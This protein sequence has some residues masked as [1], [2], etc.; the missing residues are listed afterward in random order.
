VVL[1][2]VN[3]SGDSSQDTFVDGITDSLT[4]DLSKI[5][6]SYAPFSVIARNTAFA[7]K[8]KNVDVRQIG[9]DLGVR[10]ALEGS[11]QRDQ[12]RVRVNVQLVDAESG[13]HVWTERFDKP[14]AD[15]FALQDEIVMQVGGQLKQE[16][17]KADIRRSQGSS[18]PNS[19][20]LYRQATDLV[21][22]S[23]T[24]DDMTKARDLCRRAV[25][26]DPNNATVLTCAAGL[27]FWI[28]YA[29]HPDKMTETLPT[30]EAEV[31]KALSIEPNNGEAH[32]V[33][34]YIE[35][36]S[37]RAVQGMAECERVLAV[38]PSDAAAAHGSIGSAMMYLGR[39]EETEGHINKGLRLNP[40]DIGVPYMYTTAGEAKLLLGDDEKAV[41]WL[42]GAIERNPNQPLAH[43][44]L[45][46]AL[47]RLGQPEEARAETRAGLALDP[48]F[49]IAR[50]R[51]Y[52]ESDNPTYL[53]QRDR[54]F[55]SMRKA[56]VP[57]R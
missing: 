2:F 37:K 41:A 10:Y 43:F 6:G 26:L 32:L 33:L 14:S 40:S 27:E 23:S 42:R 24:P 21:I 54:L 57:E 13:N 4:T 30:I 48:K 51:A 52:S 50:A 5:G 20:D 3:L 9:K 53:A 56:G 39:A 16:L 18:N 12:N 28:T 45:A 1:P 49:T 15:L 7:Y 55:E 34:C 35:I 44:Y 46:A 11:V 38:D 31:N 17:F 22:K 25:A 36:T 8:G 47:A 29:Y 19:M